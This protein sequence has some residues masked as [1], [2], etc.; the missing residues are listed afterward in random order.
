[1]LSYTCSFTFCLWRCR[2]TSWKLQRAVWC[3]QSPHLYT[4]P[5]CQGPSFNI[6]PKL[7]ESPSIKKTIVTLIYLLCFEKHCRYMECISHYVFCCHF[8]SKSDSLTDPRLAKLCH[9]N[10]AWGCVSWVLHNTRSI[11]WRS[12]IRKSLVGLIW[13][14]KATTDKS[15]AICNSPYNQYKNK[16][17]QCPQTP[18]KELF[19]F[20]DSGWVHCRAARLSA[21]PSEFLHNRNI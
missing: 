2:G 1:M 18:T 17:F 12:G 14:N 10:S 8:V 5:F 3:L 16:E 13:D 20:R 21:R 6:S 9:R 4:A 15:L 7:W 19:V 11:S